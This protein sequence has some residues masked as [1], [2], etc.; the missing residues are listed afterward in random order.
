MGT[1]IT[2][3]EAGKSEIEAGDPKYDWFPLAAEKY[4]S[5]SFDRPVKIGTE[6]Q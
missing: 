2:S 4:G 1:S 5:L 6:C 3:V